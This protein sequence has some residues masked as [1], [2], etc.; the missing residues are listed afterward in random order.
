[1]EAKDSL[2]VKSWGPLTLHDSLGKRV[3]IPSKRGQALFALLAC[4]KN[5][6]RSR[7]WLQSMLW[8]ERA[9]NQAQ[10]SLRWELS[11]LRAV[12]N[13]GDHV[14]I[15]ANKSMV[16][17][18]PEHI[19]FAPLD[20]SETFLEGLDIPG[21]EPWEDWLRKKRAEPRDSKDAILDSD[22]LR[23]N[24]AHLSS[25]AATKLG[26]VFFP[27]PNVNIENLQTLRAIASKLASIVSKRKWLPVKDGQFNFTPNTDT[28]IEE[29]GVRSAVSYAVKLE[30]SDAIKDAAGD[31]LTLSVIHVPTSSTLDMHHYSA[32]T[33][34]TDKTNMGQCAVAAASL[35]RVIEHAHQCA[36]I[37]K[38]D[39]D[40]TDEDMLFRARWH[41]AVLRD[42]GLA[43]AEHYISRVHPNNPNWHELKVDV[44]W[45][46]TRK[47]WL[48]RNDEAELLR[49]RNS[50][51][52][53]ILSDHTDARGYVLAATAEIWLGQAKR[54]EH[55]LQRAIELDPSFPFS[56]AQMGVA[57]QFQDEYERAIAYLE[58]SL[59]LSHNDN[60]TF[61]YEG[62]L[63]LCYFLSG[64]YDKA[65][66]YSESSLG[67]PLALLVMPLYKNCLIK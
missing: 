4:A 2:S 19:S 34:I 56:H 52:E 27:G 14:I 45:L 11:N 43:K 55:L 44:A 49:A 26:L 58:R 15:N 61:Y 40:L 66:Y 30:I 37:D 18:N 54:A 6:E 5:H 67:A 57:L 35:V 31:E 47:Q 53:V 28:T 62:E 20:L 64:Q 1:M 17:L 9:S 51:Q 10:A 12:L 39:D 8:S 41:L 48:Y 25:H 21:E 16:W 32:K 63:A 33:L 38:R 42:R 13:T 60:D 3:F 24:G 50:A 46:Q 22:S 7:N 23:E 36:A 29:I 59:Q 65:L